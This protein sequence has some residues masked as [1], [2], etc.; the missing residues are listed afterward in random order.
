MEKIVDF[1]KSWLKSSFIA[2][3]N[4]FNS[5]KKVFL[6]EKYVNIPRQ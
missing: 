6:K 2:F 3:L 5:N 1:Y 4:Y